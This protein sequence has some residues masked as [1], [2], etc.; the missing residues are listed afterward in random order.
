M[1]HNSVRESD[2]ERFP[3]RTPLQGWVVENNDPKQ[4]QRIKVRVH[5]LHDDIAD[6]DL[7]W[8]S[9]N[10]LSSYSGSVNIGDHG[11]IPKKGTKVWVYFND[12][13]QYHGVYGGAAV[14]TQ[15]QLSE[16]AGEKT[17]TTTLA[18][19]ANYDFKQ[20]YPNSDGGIDS[21]G[22]FSGH[23]DTTD[24]EHHQHVSGT[25]YSVDG[26]GNYYA[27]IN[28][29]TTRSD[30]ENATSK[31]PLGGTIVIQGNLTLFV[32][33]NVTINCSGNASIVAG[34]TVDVSCR[35]KLTVKTADQI[36]ITS[37]STNKPINIASNFAI[38]FSAP[39]VISSTPIGIGGGITPTNPS[40]PQTKP[41]LTPRS[42]PSP[43]YST[44]PQ[45]D[46]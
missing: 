10:Q 26:K 19:G 33:G 2:E 14:S 18:N 36:D 13:S 35:G 37:M 45:L 11:P 29:N 4:L 44:P 25:G 15:N 28:G 8:F 41:A 27:N 40:D 22:S 16:F 32:S 39:A 17:G 30:N 23:D 31:F 1:M 12:S 43:S 38:V 46:Y 9:P 24:L 6:E 42:R 7:P 34:G 21:S 3:V 20:N 5:N